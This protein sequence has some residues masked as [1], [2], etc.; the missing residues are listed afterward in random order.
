MNFLYEAIILHKI[1]DKLNTRRLFI[2]CFLAILQYFTPVIYAENRNTS[3]IYTRMLNITND[4][5]DPSNINTIIVFKF[6]YSLCSKYFK[7]NNTCRIKICEIF[8]T[9]TCSLI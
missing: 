6:I 8:G 2:L 3:R 5:Y 1:F 9:I 4:R 7:Y